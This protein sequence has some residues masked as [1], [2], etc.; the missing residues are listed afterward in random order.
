MDELGPRSGAVIPFVLRIGVTGHRDP[1]EAELVQSMATAAAA[2]LMDIMDEIV[3]GSDSDDLLC[4]AV[5]PRWIRVI[6]P[7]AEGA[8]RIVAQ[9][10]LDAGDAHEHWTGELTPVIPYDIDHYR[11]HDCSTAESKDAFT[12]LLER[13]GTPRM[14]HHSVPESE[15]QRDRWYRDIGR[16]VVDRCDVLM[17]LWDGTDNGKPA[18]TAATVEYALG[19][20]TPVLWIPTGRTAS[21]PAVPAPGCDRV[22]PS[23][24]LRRRRGDPS[25]QKGHS[26]AANSDNAVLRSRLVGYFAKVKRRSDFLERLVRLESYNRYA[27]RQEARLVRMVEEDLG[28]P[29]P[30][31]ANLG[32]LEAATSYF[33]PR[34][35]A[36]E[37]L[38][39]DYRRWFRQLDVCVYLLTVTAVTVGAV[40][41]WLTSWDW[42]PVAIEVGALVTVSVVTW[43]DWRR[44][45]HDR[46]VGYRAVAEYF[47]NGQFVFLVAL[48]PP[49]AASDLLPLV[50]GSLTRARIV[51]WFF[52]VIEDV[53]EQRPPH[54]LSDTDLGWVRDVVLTR[55]VADQQGWHETKA[56]DH[57]RRFGRYEKGIVWAF[58]SSVVFV[59]IHLVLSIPAMGV[60]AHWVEAGLATLVIALASTGAALNGLA[61]HLN[62]RGHAE[63]YTD[64]A[65]ELS[66]EQK[67][68]AAATTFGELR[69]GILAVRRIMLGET[70]E[71]F[72]G[73]YE[74]DIAVPT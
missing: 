69:E 68:I 23:L 72:E 14:L 4:G 17:A 65:Y 43:Q 29:A 30:P 51:P 32:A 62:H 56:A 19:Q 57:E 28:Q 73:M 8:D 11:E 15:V 24:I 25:T 42:V 6:S 1:A 35:A 41:L 7:L 27:L 49:H 2:R 46:W 31:D 52:P 74:S 47:R 40:S 63:R 50:E 33:V 5:T 10:V 3:R 44:Q 64:V 58:F 18:G 61:A 36:A 59:I 53:W 37:G 9:A 13:G 70:R 39:A 45:L 12:S 71:W 21:G 26:L 48:S 54:D 66:Q 55:W 22:E 16:H 38:A 60:H 34:R 67:G 20:G